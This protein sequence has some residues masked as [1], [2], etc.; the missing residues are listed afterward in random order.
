MGHPM[1]HYTL[2]ITTP[3]TLIITTP[4]GYLPSYLSVVF[5]LIC[6][7]WNISLHMQHACMVSSVTV[8]FI[9]FY[10]ITVYIYIQYV[11]YIQKDNRMLVCRSC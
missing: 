8:I 9:M 4:G 7:V 3:D 5:T 2:I 6:F 1:L 10:Y 11:R